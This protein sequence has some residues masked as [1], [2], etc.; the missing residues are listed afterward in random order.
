MSKV[1]SKDLCWLIT[2][3]SYSL[4]LIIF[5]FIV[6]QF[7]V[8]VV[9]FC[10]LS[11]EYPSVYLWIS[12]TKD[13]MENWKSF[14]WFLIINEFVVAKFFFL[15]HNKKWKGKKQNKNRL[16]KKSKP[17]INVDNQLKNFFRR[18]KWEKKKNRLKIWLL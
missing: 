4:L 5:T 2:P 7:H 6:Q 1:C 10:L 11:A 14:P 18:K 16:N 12:L 13:V 9:S 8:F 3:F 17:L 15:S